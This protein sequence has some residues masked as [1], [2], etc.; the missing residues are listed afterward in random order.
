MS[1]D[2]PK[3]DI[4]PI[5]NRLKGVVPTQTVWGTAPTNLERVTD[6]DWAS[7]TGTGTTIMGGAGNFGYLQFDMGAAYKVTVRGKMGLWATGPTLI[8]THLQYSDDGITWREMGGAWM[9]ATS[10]AEYVIF[11]FELLAYARYLQI[12]FYVAGA[13]TANAKIYEVE[14]VDIGL[15]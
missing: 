7:V 10:L 13:A 12:R 8:S 6:G 11:S 3:F 5:K 15:Y 1:S 4:W 14:A 9:Y 2:L